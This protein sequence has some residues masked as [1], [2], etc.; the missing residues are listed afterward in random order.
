MVCIWFACLIAVSSCAQQRKAVVKAYAFYM[1]PTPGTIPVDENG[2]PL[3]YKIDTVF[4]VFVETRNADMQWLRAWKKNASFALSSSRIKSG[5]IVVGASRPEN[6]EIRLRA[7][8][9][10]TL[11]QLHLS[12]EQ[13]TVSAPQSLKGQD[14]L[15]Q[16]KWKNGTVYHTI[17]SWTALASPLFQ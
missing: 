3:E 9:G 10:H 6:K 1:V 13:K 12:A 11:W 14:L 4:S 17:R 2:Q 8:E 5:S 15:L 16:G 7:K